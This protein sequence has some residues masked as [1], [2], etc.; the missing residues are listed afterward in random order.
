MADVYDLNLSTS[1]CLSATFFWIRAKRNFQHA[2]VFP[3]DLCIDDYPILA[4]S[5][6]PLFVI[7]YTS[8]IFLS[9]PVF[10]FSVSLQSLR[11][12]SEPSTSDLTASSRNIVYMRFN[13]R[14]VGLLLRRRCVIDACFWGEKIHLCLSLRQVYYR[15]YVGRMMLNLSSSKENLLTRLLQ[16]QTYPGHCSTCQGA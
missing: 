7:V 1:P 13:I 10:S 15:S 11:K 9:S 8:S 3:T 6:F 12:Y 2:F 4:C 5:T 16:H 14:V